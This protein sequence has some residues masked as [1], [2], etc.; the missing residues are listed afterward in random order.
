MELIDVWERYQRGVEYKNRINLYST[1]DENYNYFQGEQWGDTKVEGL[2]P[3]VFNFIKPVIRYK[4]STIMQNDT[5]IIYRCGNN[6]DP[7]YN[8]LQDVAD[9]LTSY[10]ETLWEKLKMDFTNEIMLQEGA[11]T[12]DGIAYFYFDEE[13]KEVK[14]DLIDNTNIYPANPNDTDLQA[15]EHIIISFRRSVKSVKDEAKANGIT[16]SDLDLITSDTDT[17]ELAGANA[18]I[19]IDNNDMCIVLLEMWKQDGTVWY[20]KCVKGL[21]FISDTNTGL[22]LYP[23]GKFTWENQKN[24]FFGISDVTGLIPNQDYVNTIAAMIMSST[25]F[26]AFPKMIYDESLVENPSNQ[27]GV[28]I[29]VKGSSQPLKN[30]I[31]YIN[32]GSMSSDVFQMFDKTLTLTKE[33]MGANDGALGNV[34]PENASG[35]SILA[36]MEQTALPLESVK[37]RYYNYL[38]DVALIWADMWRI[39]SAGGKQIDF[40]D[41]NGE[42][43]AGTIDQSAFERLMLTAKIDVGPS[44]RWSELSTIETLGNLLQSKH[45]PFDWYVQ[46]LPDSSGLP[47]KKLLD[48]I[49]QQKQQAMQQQQLEQQAQMQSEQQQAQQTPPNFDVDTFIESMPEEQ[50]MQVLQN[51]Q[52]LEQMIAERMRVQQ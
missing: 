30:V 26:T 16:E 7:Q 8:E 39:Y 5:K 19:E 27:I 52:M 9:K 17:I 37:R 3:P 33:L 48:M 41:E 29:G 6:T 28:A 23:I 15:Q 38:V 36:V 1:I 10:S 2:P 32:P 18:K 51:P 45:I 49:E 47:K 40:T 50:Q 42:T 13:T 35:R 34:N 20:N 21:K 4:I 11:I 25:T 14:V 12:G 22:K 43:E 31:D 24:S 46:L 44:T